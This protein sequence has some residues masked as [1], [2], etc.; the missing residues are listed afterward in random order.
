MI[1]ISIGYIVGFYIHRYL[2]YHY[3]IYIPVFIMGIGC[4][5]IIYATLFLKENK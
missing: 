2:H 5:M 4:A 1:G 3:L